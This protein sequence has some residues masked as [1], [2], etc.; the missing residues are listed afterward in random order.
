MRHVSHWVMSHVTAY[1]VWMSHVTYE[2]VTSHV[3]ESCHVWMGHVTHDWVMSHTYINSQV[4]LECWDY[5][6]MSHMNES[7]WMSHVT[8][9]WV[10]LLWISH[11]AFEWV[12]SRVNESCHTCMSYVTHTHPHTHINSKV[13]LE[14][15]DYDGAS[16]DDQIGIPISTAKMCIYREN[17]YI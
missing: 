12:T 6:G 5:N 14:C 4:R 7:C 13:R 1:H 2:W 15:W 16:G 9:E 17:M 3:N 8:H 11:F 10:M